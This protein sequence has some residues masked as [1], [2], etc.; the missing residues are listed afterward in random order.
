[1]SGG[2]LTHERTPDKGARR[3]RWLLAGARVAL[4]LLVVASVV[5][6][7]SAATYRVPGG[8][9][10]LR[11]R[12]AWPGGRL[13]MPLGPAGR[14]E[15]LTHKT[16]VDL[17]VRFEL[18]P[19]GTLSDIGELTQRLP[20]ARAGAEQ[21]FASFA[22]WKIPWLAVLGLA[23]GLLA[24]SYGPRLLRR[25]ALA[26][27]LGLTGVAV[28]VGALAGV[29]YATL[30]RTPSVSY[31]GIAQDLPR[32]VKVVRNVS[33]VLEGRDLGFGEF[34]AALETI[35]QQLA[36][37][38]NGG[39]RDNMVRLLLVTD[40]HL[41]PVGAR[42]AARL[43]SSEVEHVDAVLLGGDMTYFGTELEGRLFATAFGK[44]SVPVL[45]VG[46]NH[47]SAPAMDYF[48]TLG[49]R[50]LDAATVE[51]RGV[52]IMGFSDPVAGTPA[53]IASAAELDQAATAEADAWSTA[54]PPP[55]V[56]LVHEVAQAR[57]I[58]A[59]ARE[60][61]VQLV[62]MYG[63]DH[64]VKVTREGTVTLVDGGTAGA[65]GVE[66][67]GVAPGTPYT[68]QIVEF[69]QSEGTMHPVSVITLSYSGDGSS[70]AEFQP[71]TR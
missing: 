6:L 70:Q 33:D 68:F 8:E 10:T 55:N 66:R 57:K 47:E 38:G 2:G 12:P 29:S 15:M 46:G 34:V 18:A 7:L 41:N 16:P 63:H 54:Q 37:G 1:M 17:E 35:S 60:R 65:S 51:V 42:L 27:G 26:A 44:V 50:L 71:L 24:V 59:L 39:E 58:I 43:A 32:V 3:R 11:L 14:V 23:V 4:V 45:M 52:G 40:V 67:L 22:L 69:A 13:V 64:V 49:W 36:A 31:Y 53:L 30:D 19:Q 56:V 9:I 28:L 5:E 48:A 61:G 20:A 62:V 25:G 21:A